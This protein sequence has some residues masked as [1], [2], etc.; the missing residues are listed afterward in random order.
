ME[1][2][3]RGGLCVFVCVFLL[4]EANSRACLR[5]TWHKEI[6]AVGP[7]SLRRQ[8]GKGFR[9]AGLASGRKSLFPVTKR[10]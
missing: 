4:K 6:I 7:G 5:M 10:R 8:S 2:V 9:R 3:L 1:H